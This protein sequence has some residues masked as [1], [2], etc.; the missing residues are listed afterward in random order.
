M[1]TP[2]HHTFGPLA[3]W[4]QFWLSVWIQCLP[5]R[6]KRGPDTAKLEHALSTHFGA[7][8]ITFGSGRHG[9]LALLRSINLQPGEEVILQSYTCVVL[10]NA[11]HAAGG[12]PIYAEIERETLNIDM[13]D[14]KRC[15]TPRTRAILCQH[16]F[17]IPADTAALRKICDEHNLILIEDC[18]HVLPDA[19]GPHEI[20]K[21]GDCVMLSF[22]RDKAISGVTGGAIVSRRAE[23]TAK[24]KQQQA[25]AIDMPWLRLK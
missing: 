5:W 21:H 17:G 9:I 10:P 25:Q 11:I 20:G 19:K 4:R 8:T 24:L 3:D 18:A 22:G 16:T 1:F 6:Y 13:A 15:I 23:I 2:I 14:L 12:V 7:E